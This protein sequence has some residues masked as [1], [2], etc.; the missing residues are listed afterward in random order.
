MDDAGP[1]SRCQAAARSLQGNSL[2]AACVL[3]ISTVSRFLTAPSACAAAALLEPLAEAAREAAGVELR[4]H[5]RG[6]AEDGGAQAKTLLDAVA[7]AADAVVLGT[8]TKVGRNRRCPCRSAWS[9][10]ALLSSTL[11]GLALVRVL[12][13]AQLG[14]A[15][16]SRRTRARK[17]AGHQLQEKQGRSSTWA[18]VDAS[19]KARAL[20]SPVAICAQEKPAGKQAESWAAELK[21]RELQTVDIGL[22]VGARPQR[23]L[24]QFLC[25]QELL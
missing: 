12:S 11:C 21:S 16:I 17:S 14:Y 9:A 20:V 13:P 7:A 6:K 25:R 1:Q 10:V 22:A 15:H 19:L 2:S 23:D 4:L 8:L 18:P 3:S 24:W 5:T